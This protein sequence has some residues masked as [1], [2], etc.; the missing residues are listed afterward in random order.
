MEVRK[1]NKASPEDAFLLTE[2][3]KTAKASW[4]YDESL[5]KIWEEDLTIKPA[6]V[7]EWQ[8]YVAMID[9]ETVGFCMINVNNNPPEIEHLWISPAHHRKGFG[10]TILKFALEDIAND[11]STIGVV[12][13]PF[14]EAFYEKHGFIKTHEIDGKPKGR[15]LPFLLLKF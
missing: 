5:L 11:F 3:A 14:A 2:I 9:N 7:Q 1:I 8:T 12:S 6:M 10:Q 15:R 4:G 13:D